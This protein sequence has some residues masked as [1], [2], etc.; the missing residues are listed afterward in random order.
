M[1]SAFL[2]N[3]EYLEYQIMWRQSDKHPVIAI[4]T[5]RQCGEQGWGSSRVCEREEDRDG[6]QTTPL[7][8]G[9]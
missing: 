7:F 9:E 5:A 4:P 1:L 3:R 8:W 2:E 6:E